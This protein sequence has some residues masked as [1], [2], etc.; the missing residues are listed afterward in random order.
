MRKT[1]LALAAAAMTAL[2]APGVAQ[3]AGTTA[4]V[5]GLVGTELSLTAGTPATLNLTHAAPATAFSNVAVTSTNASWTLKVKDNDGTNTPGFMD[6]CDAL[7]ALL[8]PLS[9]LSTQLQWSGDAGV[10]W[11][12]LSGTDANVGTGSLMATKQVNFKQGLTGT[13]AV[14]TGDRYCLTVAYTVI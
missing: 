14:T 13:D 9:S 11:N 2:V 6:K 7:G 5:A 1:R 10:T 4:P 8:T 3:A 12:N